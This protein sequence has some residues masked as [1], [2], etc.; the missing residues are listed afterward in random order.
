MRIFLAGATG[1]IGTRL[2]PL[3]LEDGPDVAGMTRAADKVEARARMGVDVGGVVMRYGTSYGPGTYSGSEGVPGPPR[4]H[5]DEA[6]RRTVA[7][8]DAPSGVVVIAEDA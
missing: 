5:V 2:V 7:L 4:I 6:A 8:L 1:V 3:L